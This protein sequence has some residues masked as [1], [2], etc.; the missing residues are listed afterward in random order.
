M[1]GSQ[2]IGTECQEGSHSLVPSDQGQ[3]FCGSRSSR[4]YWSWKPKLKLAPGS[5]TF[6]LWQLCTYT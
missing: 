5:C 1:N 4:V 2:E 6:M 3:R